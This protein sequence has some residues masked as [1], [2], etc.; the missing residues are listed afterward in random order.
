[1][2]VKVEVTLMGWLGELFSGYSGPNVVIQGTRF[3][4][5]QYGTAAVMWSAD[6]SQGVVKAILHL[7]EN[8][9]G[10]DTIYTRAA[11]NL[12]V[13]QLPVIPLHIATYAYALL[14]LPGASTLM[15]QEFRKGMVNSLRRCYS[16]T[17]AEV[18]MDLFQYYLKLFLEELDSARRSALE[19]SPISAAVSDFICKGLSELDVYPARPLLRIDG[20]DR[21]AITL[22]V[23]TSI[24]GQFKAYDEM[25]LH[26]A[27]G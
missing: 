11:A 15:V 10:A 2:N 9:P 17:R 22:V 24:V 19:S 13:A 23:A 18:S 8:R 7:G 5:E 20:I 3:T 27:P 21:E 12:S 6:S 1:M 16:Q 25:N 26:I 4:P 14:Q